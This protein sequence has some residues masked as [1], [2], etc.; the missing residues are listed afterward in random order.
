MPTSLDQPVSPP[1]KKA[2]LNPRVSSSESLKADTSLP[3]HRS[4]FQLTEI[5]DLPAELNRDTIKLKDL[6]GDPL[7]C[8]CWEFNYLHDIDFLMSHFDEDIRHLVK[9]HVVHGFWKKEDPHRHALQVCVPLPDCSFGHLHG[10]CY[11][12]SLLLAA[13]RNSG[14]RWADHQNRKPPPRM[15]MWPFTL[16]SYRKFL[17]PIIPR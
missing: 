2:R 16:P 14:G 13:S 1:R 3:G 11:L 9:V 5:R 12:L 17:A 8:E 4:P 7:I 15:R 10:L 6:L